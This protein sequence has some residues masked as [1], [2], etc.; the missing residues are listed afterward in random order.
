MIMHVMSACPSLALSAIIYRHNFALRIVY[1]HLVYA[2]DIDTTPVL[3]Y[4][5]NDIESMM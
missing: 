2:Y 3:L 4:V 1:Y 5:P